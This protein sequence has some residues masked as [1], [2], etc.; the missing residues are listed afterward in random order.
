MS[1]CRL[2]LL[3]EEAGAAWL[4]RCNAVLTFRCLEAQQRHPWRVN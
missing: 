1:C 3:P 2:A 4:V